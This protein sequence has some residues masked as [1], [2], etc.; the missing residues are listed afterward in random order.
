MVRE[1]VE[2]QS[3]GDLNEVK[4]LMIWGYKGKGA[5]ILVGVCGWLV[6]D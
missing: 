5:G 3:I 6:R 4:S 2:G 1:K